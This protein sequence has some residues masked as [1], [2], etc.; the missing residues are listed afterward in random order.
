MNTVQNKKILF[1]SPDFF[2]IDKIIIQILEEQGA[3]VSWIN[4]R[5]V[6]SDL[7]VR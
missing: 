2:G 6:K 7:D 4:E 1:I 3:S 5:S